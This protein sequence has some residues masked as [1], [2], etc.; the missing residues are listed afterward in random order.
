V[1]TWCEQDELFGKERTYC[2]S[3]YLEDPNGM[4]CE[5]TH[6]HAEVETIN[7]IRLDDAHSALKRWLAVWRPPLQQHVPLIGPRQSFR[8]LSGASP[9]SPYSALAPGRL[10]MVARSR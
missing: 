10:A 5:F 9:F 3:I 8:P 1:A 4:I 7:K 6:D 2:R